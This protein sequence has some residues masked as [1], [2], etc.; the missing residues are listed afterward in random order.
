VNNKISSL[1]DIKSHYKKNKSQLFSR[2]GLIH[3]NK[4]IKLSTKKGRLPA[5][6]RDG[7]V[8]TSMNGY[9]MMDLDNEIIS[10]IRKVKISE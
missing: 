9:S 3:T 5:G 1:A 6:L 7:D 10:S 2:C 8:I 4:G